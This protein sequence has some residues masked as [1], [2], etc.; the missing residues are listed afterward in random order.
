MINVSSNYG[1][2]VADFMMG[3]GTIPACAKKLGRKSIG[4]EKKALYF[5]GSKKR[6][7]SVP[8]LEVKS[9]NNLTKKT[10]DWFI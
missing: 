2:L 4:I 9:H 10:M 5:K 7:Q 1:D 6:L 8:F 3:V